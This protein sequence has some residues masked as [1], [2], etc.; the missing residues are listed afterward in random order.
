MNLPGFTAARAFEFSAGPM[1]YAAGARIGM[2]RL[3]ISMQSMEPNQ[4]KLCSTHA[5]CGRF[6]CC[7]AQDFGP[8]VCRAGPCNI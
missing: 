3:S 7:F 2:G 4:L 1:S 5:D 8:N 6:Q